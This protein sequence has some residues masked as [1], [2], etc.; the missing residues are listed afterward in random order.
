MQRS[1]EQGGRYRDIGKDFLARGKFFDAFVNFNKS[2]CF[3]EPSSD[4]I[5]LTFEAR[6]EAFFSCGLFEKCL[7][8]VHNARRG[9]LSGELLEKLTRLEIECK[10]KL[11]ESEN[12]S[13]DFDGFFE[14]TY[15]PNATIP[16]IIDGL[17]LHRNEK[18]GRHLITTRDLQPGDVLAVEPPHFAFLSPNAV[19]EKCFNCL[20]SNMLDLYPGNSFAMFCSEKCR[21]ETDKKFNFKDELVQNCLTGSDI[22]Q[23]MIRIMSD[24]MDAA[25]SFEDLKALVESSDDK[26]LFDFD[27]S[28]LSDTQLTKTVL[29]CVNALIPKQDFGITDYLQGA[30]CLPAGDKKDFFV[31]FIAR[32]ILI[33][34]RNGVKLPGREAASPDGGLLLA[35]VP[36]INHSCDPNLYANFVDNKCIITVLKPIATGEQLFVNYR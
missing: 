17:E 14:L 9:S 34:M 36:M 19:F 15:P 16:F 26:S 11:I 10:R 4:E 6:S 30:L 20:R 32:I 7:E 35:F 31:N 2:L 21:S 8:N 1:N 24:A 18:F 23:K 27:F 22:N 25:G 13:T 33:Y 29:T 3:S 28:D 12:D 5:S